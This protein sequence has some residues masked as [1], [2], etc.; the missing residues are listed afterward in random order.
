MLF[1]IRNV[2]RTLSRA[3]RSNARYL[4]PSPA[5]PRRYT[6]RFALASGTIVGA[7]LLPAIYA[8]APNETLNHG[9]RVPLTSAIRSYIVYSMCS[10]PFVVDHSPEVLST[11]MSIPVV[12]QITEAFVR[13]SFF[14][15]VSLLSS[16]Q[17]A[18]PTITIHIQFVGG[19]TAQDALPLIRKLRAENKG[20]L[21]GYSVEVD[22]AEASGKHVVIHERQPH[23]RIV[24]EMLRA[25]DVAADFEDQFGEGMMSRSRRTWVAVKI[26]R[27]LF[28]IPKLIFE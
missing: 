5:T 11:L 20:A 28:F 9:D 13:A 14:S 27:V 2:S 26:V 10:V 12:K 22:E 25:I 6:G 16:Y 21:L 7:L 23:K 3:L 1:P 17:C 15:Q 8:D 19:D 4:H 18:I 24:D